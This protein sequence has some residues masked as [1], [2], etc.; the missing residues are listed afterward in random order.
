MLEKLHSV[1]CHERYGAK[2]DKLENIWSYKLVMDGM[3]LI[4]DK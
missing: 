3:V 1:A 4:M 2:K